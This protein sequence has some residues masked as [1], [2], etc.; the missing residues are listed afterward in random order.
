M[1]VAELR[2]EADIEHVCT[3]HDM[4]QQH[5]VSSLSARSLRSGERRGTPPERQ[6]RTT[7]PPA[8]SRSLCAPFA[9]WAPRLR[10]RAQRGNAKARKARA[11]SPAAPLGRGAGYRI[12]P[13]PLCRVGDKDLVALERDDDRR[14]G[15]SVALRCARG[16]PG[17]VGPVARRLSNFKSTRSR[18]RVAVWRWDWR[19]GRLAWAVERVS[20]S[21]RGPIWSR[22]S[23]AGAQRRF[24]GLSNRPAAIAAVREADEEPR[25][26][27]CR[28]SQRGGAAL[29][30]FR[31]VD[32]HGRR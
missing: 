13:P 31:S 7:S 22:S 30:S 25:S 12:S 16:A 24:S 14:G 29:D 15:S 10:C 3:K 2:F 4:T 8:S 32:Q 23:S 28:A 21:R 17:R 6:C 18:V 19:W 26:D 9:N 20:R 5:A 11:I 1:A 27:N